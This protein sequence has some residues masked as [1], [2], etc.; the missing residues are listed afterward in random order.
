MVVAGQRHVPAVVPQE[1][2]GT[3]FIGG[4]AGHRAGLEVCG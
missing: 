2:H 4:W 3:H 1:R